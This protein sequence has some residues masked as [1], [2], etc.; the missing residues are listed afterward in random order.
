LRAGIVQ[1]SCLSSCWSGFT[2]LFSSCWAQAGNDNA[3][4]GSGGGGSG[5]SGG[6]G[7]YVNL[8]TV[9]VKKEKIDELGISSQDNVAQR[10]Y[11]LDAT[12]YYSFGLITCC[13]IVYAR[14]AA[15]S[16]AAHYFGTRHHQQLSQKILDNIQEKEGRAVQAV[17]VFFSAE[18]KQNHAQLTNAQR[19]F[20]E[21]LEKALGNA[22]Y[23][24][25]VYDA[26]KTTI[27]LKAD[28]TYAMSVDKEVTLAQ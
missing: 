19:I 22:A 10:A 5:G 8:S 24:Y 17:K 20:K 16:T 14:G 28:G 9:V 4:G 3:G 18:A 27:I 26:Y 2:S 25:F 12:G 15:S 1:A 7:G 21:A 6:S 11:S 23:Q 13:T